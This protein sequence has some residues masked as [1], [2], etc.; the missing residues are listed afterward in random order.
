MRRLPLMLLV[1]S[2]PAHAAIPTITRD[3]IIS[4]AKSG[5]GCPYVWGGTCWDPA[6][7]KWKGADCSGYVTKCWQIPTATKTTDCVSHYYT[8]YTFLNST[9]HWT[10]ISRNDLLKGDALVYNTGSAGH[11]IL[12]YSGDKWGNAQVYEA[13]G[14]AYGIIY[15]TK[16]VDSSYAARR[17]NSIV[18]PPP[19]A[20]TY[21]LMT[22]T[23][24]IET[25][26]GQ[27][28]DF[29]K[30]GDS[31]GIFDWTAGQTTLAHVDVKNSGS[32]VAKNVKVGLWSEEPYLTTLKWTIY[33]DW[34]STGFV[35]NDTD[36]LQSVSHDNP[37]QSFTLNLGSISVGETKRIKLEIQAAVFSIGAADHPDVRA[38]ISSVDGYYTKASFSSSFTNVSSYQTQNGGDLRSYSQTD[39]LAGETCDGKDNDCDGQIDEEDVC[40][41]DAGVDTGRAADT[42][43]GPAIDPL[44]GPYVPSSPASP[45]ADALSGG[46]SMGHGTTSSGML[47]LVVLLLLGWRSRHR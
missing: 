32:A 45:T 15:R 21:P 38:W 9:T 35:L 7:K 42:D 29:C 3:Q 16:Y 17:R 26:S 27:D 8:T 37:G 34:N 30:V 31:S 18:N 39:V 6:N 11:V 44:P 24:S 33:T 19:P 13:R 23:S 28:R 41:A 22:I 12:Y 36:G 14:T 10:K 40:S 20:P 43:G 5:V 47:T 46:C 2:I 4:I 1:L 25:I